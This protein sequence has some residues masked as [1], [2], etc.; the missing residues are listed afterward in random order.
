MNQSSR[1]DLKTA[2]RFLEASSSL[3]HDLI[4]NTHHHFHPNQ[5]TDLSQM[6][7]YWTLAHRCYTCGANYKNSLASTAAYWAEAL[8]F[9][10]PVIF[11]RSRDGRQVCFEKIQDFPQ[12][13]NDELQCY[14]AYIHP[15]EGDIA[16]LTDAQILQYMAIAKDEQDDNESG[17]LSSL[18]PYFIQPDERRLTIKEAIAAEVYREPGQLDIQW[19]DGRKYGFHRRSRGGC[20]QIH[21]DVPYTDPDPGA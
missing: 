6:F 11:E 19:G 18:L 21:H 5:D 10:G 14:A 3:L 2:F 16:Q 1:P 7:H 8:I 20:V 12:D 9:G 4:S 13:S 17:S 15:R